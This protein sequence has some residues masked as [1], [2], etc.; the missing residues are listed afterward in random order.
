MFS[1]FKLYSY[2][3]LHPQRW[4]LNRGELK[5]LPWD[6]RV[7][8][9]VRNTGAEKTLKV[10]S[11]TGSL[12]ACPSSGSRTGKLLWLFSYCRCTLRDRCWRINFTTWKLLWKKKPTWHKILLPL[13]VPNSHFYVCCSI[14]TGS[15]LE[16]RHHWN[17]FIIH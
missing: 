4:D 7:A 10:A 12:P 6:R 17:C 1:W 3:T 8:K 11:R 5:T 14:N 13:I 15:F 2:S 9:V 16:Q